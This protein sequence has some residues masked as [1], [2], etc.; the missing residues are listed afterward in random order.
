MQGKPGDFLLAHPLLDD[1]NFE[2]S[3]VLL[4]QWDEEG[5]AGLIINRLS[6]YTLDQ[7]LEGAWPAWQLYFGGPVRTDSLYFLHQRPDL[8]SGGAILSA[9]LYFGGDFDAMHYAVRNELLAEDE[10]LF[11]AGYAG[12]TQG[13]LEGELEEGSWVLQS[14]EHLTNWW[15]QDQLYQNL[16]KNWPD[17]L[18]FWMNKPE[19]PYWN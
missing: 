12:W 4:T 6:D 2:R 5:A 13:Q 7:A 10:I 11:T 3:V 9:G 19:V 14:A 1:E 16:A 18:K 17:D 15:K 8:I